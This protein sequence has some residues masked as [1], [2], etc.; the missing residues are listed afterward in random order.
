[1][2]RPRWFAAFPVACLVLALGGPAARAQGPILSGAGPIN[3][4][5]GGA[6][7]AAPRGATGTLYWNPAGIGGLS[8]SELDLG[9]ELF[10]PRST[11]SSSIPA[12]ALG[13][14]FPPVTLAGRT[15]DEVGVFAL[16]SGGF[17]YRPECSNW[18][19]GLGLFPTSGF[20]VNYPV[21]PAN[22]ILSP[23]PNGLGHIS[24]LYQLFQLA[25]TVAYQV[26]DRLSVGLAP[27]INIARLEATPGLFLSPD[28]ANADRVPSSPAATSTRNAWGGGFQVGVYYVASDAWQF[29]AAFRSPQWFEPFRYNTADELGRPRVAKFRLEAPLIV[30]VGAAYTGLERLTVA[31]DLR[32]INFHDTSGLRTAGFDPTGAITGLGWRDVFSAALGVQY[33]LTCDCSVRLGYTYNTNPIPSQNALFNI[34]SPLTYQ[35]QLAVGVSYRLTPG[36]TLSACYYH[37]FSGSVSGPFV[38]P[39][40]PIPGGRVTTGTEVDSLIV[41]ASVRF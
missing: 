4:S 36:C 11:L 27:I 7:T 19:F 29:G 31:T 41:G 14:G 24:S 23:P 21:D 32:Y 38:T 18:T 6:S 35:H 17:V 34:A 20:G 22:P 12:G 3:R 25:P 5:M 15:R 2:C 30:S 33:Q 1:M 39:M 16:P 9:L 8:S 10:Y 28:D 26:T 13:P 40:G 37:I